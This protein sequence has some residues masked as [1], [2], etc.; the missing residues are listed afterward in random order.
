[1]RWFPGGTVARRFRT[2]FLPAAS[3]E[4]P[5]QAN[6]VVDPGDD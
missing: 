5:Q 3:E 2:W 6:G 1:M 4:T